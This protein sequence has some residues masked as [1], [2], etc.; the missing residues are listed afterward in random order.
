[1][2][3]KKQIVSIY[4]DTEIVKY[5]DRAWREAGLNRSLMVEFALKEG[6]ARAYERLTKVRKPV[7]PAAQVSEPVHLETDSPTA[8]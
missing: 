7:L 8:L 4:L 5:L 3:A 1:M 6:L 2:S